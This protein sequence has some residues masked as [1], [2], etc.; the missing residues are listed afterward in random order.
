MNNES[1]M[2]KIKYCTRC[3][4]P[5]TQEGIQF[6]SMGICTACQS[7]EQKMHIDWNRLSES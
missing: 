2:P 4:M 6:D 3:C 1:K 7:S 5:E